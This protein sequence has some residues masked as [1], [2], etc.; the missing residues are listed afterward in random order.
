MSGAGPSVTP[1]DARATVAQ[2]RAQAARA[3]MIVAD[4]TGLDEAARTAARVPVIVVDRPGWAK[5]AAQLAGDVI[6]PYMGSGSGPLADAMASA[7]I[8]VG[9]SAVA[10]RVL[11]QYDPFWAGPQGAGPLPGGA[12]S[13]QEPAAGRLLLVAPN[14]RAFGAAYS[15]DRQDLALWICVHELTHAIQFAAAPW[16]TDYIH[17]RARALLELVEAPE[18]PFTFDSGPGADLT[19]L[20][21]LLEGHAEFVMNE[22]PIA[23]MPGKRHLID[24]MKARREAGSPIAA[25]L[26]R[27]I[28]LD[29]KSAQYRDG[30]AFVREVVRQA[31]HE[32]LNV[33]W[34]NPLFAPSLEEIAAPSAWIRRVVG[35]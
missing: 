9:V 23:R 30:V 34:A 10:M 31:G 17:S 19:A 7:E 4:V 20:M 8:A 24:A 32:G 12:A 25:F 16:L 13:L 29:L 18:R 26:Q 6:G 33:V 22:V 21:S 15:L 11:G 3:P 5:A 28:G 2:L 1:A 35:A 27:A 14:V